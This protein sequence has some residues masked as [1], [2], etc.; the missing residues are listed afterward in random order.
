MNLGSFWLREASSRNLWHAYF[1]C[2][3]HI[4]VNIVFRRVA[5]LEDVVV[6]PVID[7]ENAA[8]T[9]ERVKVFDGPALL[10]LVAVKVGEMRERVAHADEGVEAGRAP[11]D[12]DVLV[13]G[14]PVGLLDH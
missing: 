3:T 5:L 7:D 11:R 14:Q 8:R 12:L 9:D 10:P 2:C 6:V 13:E 1:I 4:V